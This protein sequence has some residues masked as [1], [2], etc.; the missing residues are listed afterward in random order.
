LY[1]VAQ[2]RN[3]VDPITVY[4]STEFSG[5]LIVRNFDFEL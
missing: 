4:F 5:L 1:V 3:T 2:R